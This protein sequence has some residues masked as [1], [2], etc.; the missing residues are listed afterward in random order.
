MMMKSSEHKEPIE[1]TVPVRGDEAFYVMDNTGTNFYEY[2]HRHREFQITYVVEGKGALMLGNLIRPCLEN[3]LYLIKPNDPHLFFKDEHI[4]EEPRIRIIHLFFSLE[5]LR[6]FFDMNE[7]SVV[8]SLFYSMDASKLLPEQFAMP[9]KELFVSLYRK[10]GASKLINLL[11]IFKELVAREDKFI[12]MYSGLS[13][14]HFQEADG[15][16]IH[17]VIKYAIENY[18]RTISIEEV[19][20]LIH[21]T[22]TAFCKFFKKHTQKT[23]ISFLNEIRIESA[24]QLLVNNKVESI[25]ETAYQCGFNTAVHFN[26]VFLHVM[27]VSPK[28][29]IAARTR[30]R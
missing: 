11:N 16:R 9:L 29:F 22:P 20:A 5:K 14:V 30:K 24:C 23:F 12:S 8:K 6:P 28:E 19:S 15:L 3:Q 26:R 18:R 17:T 10:E 25:A 7:M 21:L 27:K 2:Y 4:A 1:F 13:K